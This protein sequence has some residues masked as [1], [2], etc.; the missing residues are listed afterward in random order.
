MPGQQ[1]RENGE[2]GE[3][4]HARSEKE[5]DCVFHEPLRGSLAVELGPGTFK[6]VAFGGSELVDDFVHRCLGFGLPA[7]PS[8][9]ACGFHQEN[10]SAEGL[11]PRPVARDAA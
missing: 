11:R 2:P 8:G 1:Q 7:Q 9:D 3:E 5:L 4:A 6:P 10:E